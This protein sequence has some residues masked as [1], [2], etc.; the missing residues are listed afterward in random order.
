MSTD[1]L[2]PSFH[3]T[4]FPCSHCGATVGAECRSKK[5]GKLVPYHSPRLRAAAVAITKV[6]VSST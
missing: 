5:T 4:A 3:V 2:N 1:P 6:M